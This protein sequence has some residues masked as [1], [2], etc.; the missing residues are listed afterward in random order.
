MTDG[1]MMGFAANTPHLLHYTTGFFPN[2][3]LV[4]ADIWLNREIATRVFLAWPLLRWEW[5]VGSG[6][7]ILR[8][9]LYNV[10][11]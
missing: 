1:M 10:A 11:L 3:R 6:L 2:Q 8:A 4:D 9:S 7:D 5:P